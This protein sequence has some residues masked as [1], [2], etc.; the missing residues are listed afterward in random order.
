MIVK[1]ENY[2]YVHMCTLHA[3][4]DMRVHAHTDLHS[5]INVFGLA[6]SACKRVVKLVF[7]D[8]SASLTH[9]HLHNNTFMMFQGFENQ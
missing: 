1:C 5:G 4:A 3:R 9:V 6:I 2:A 8:I 7:V